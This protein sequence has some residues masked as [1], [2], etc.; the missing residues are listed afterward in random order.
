MIHDPIRTCSMH[1]T[2][3]IYNGT[4]GLFWISV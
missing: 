2:G 1:Q 3:E 4:G